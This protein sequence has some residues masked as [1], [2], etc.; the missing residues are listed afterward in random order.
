MNQYAY[1]TALNLK[2]EVLCIGN[3][4]QKSL[5]VSTFFRTFRSA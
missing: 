2:P 3:A 4:L 1:I 5:P